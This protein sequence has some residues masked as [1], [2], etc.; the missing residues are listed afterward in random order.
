MYLRIEYSDHNE[1]FASCLPRDGKV[2]SKPKCMDSNLDWHLLRLNKLII[3]R[4]AEYSHLLIASRWKHH[5]IGEDKPVSVFILLVPT[6]DPNV[7]NEFSYQQYPF[8]A[9]GIATLIPDTNGD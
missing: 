8:V 7:P 6:A 2:V 1:S 9:W 3:Y 4:D 5:A